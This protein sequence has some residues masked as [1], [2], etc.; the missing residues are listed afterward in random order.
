L[1]CQESFDKILTTNRFLLD[2]GVIELLQANIATM[3]ERGRGEKKNECG[4]HQLS[5][6]IEEKGSYYE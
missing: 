1:L 2:G 5:N 3:Q 4:P 6:R